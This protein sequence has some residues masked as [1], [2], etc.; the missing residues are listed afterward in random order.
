MP[1]RECSPAGPRPSHPA[2]HLALPQP[3]HSFQTA[4]QG[5]LAVPRGPTPIFLE[6]PRRSF[7]HFAVSIHLGICRPHTTVHPHEKMCLAHRRS[8]SM[9]P[10]SQKALSRCECVGGGTDKGGA[11]QEEMSAPPEPQAS[12]G[13]QSRGT[14]SSCSRAL[15]LIP[16]HQVTAQPR[17]PGFIHRKTRED[18]FSSLI[19]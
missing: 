7:S 3:A 1:Y 6:P 2:W 14:R 19:S 8:P 5:A 12:M 18:H 17:R 13:P 16:G 15:M 9:R 11:G 4:P 10:G